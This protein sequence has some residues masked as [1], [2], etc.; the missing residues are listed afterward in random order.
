MAYD[1]KPN[2]NTSLEDINTITN[3]NTKTMIDRYV[4]AANFC[5]GKDVLDCA[6]GHGYGAFILRGLGARF[7]Q[8]LDIDKETV[9]IL[10]RRKD[11]DSIVVA[12]ED[13]TRP[14]N[15]WAENNY[16]VVVSIE[17]FEHVPREGVQQMLENFKYV[18]KPGGK[19]IITTPCRHTESFEYKGGTHLYE[20]NIN[21]FIGELQRVFKNIEMHYI[22]EFRHPISPELNSLFTQDHQFA[23]KCSVMVAVITNE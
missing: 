23:D 10:A 9:D 11:T 4:W 14:L 21:E 16:D 3:P 7:V 22:I 1:V 12:K 5:K 13:I 17:T 6:S 8:C 15:D 19:I 20:Y 2:Q 18:C